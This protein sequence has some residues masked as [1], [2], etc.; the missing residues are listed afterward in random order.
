MAKLR[1]AR[2]YRKLERP[3]TRKSKYRKLSYIRSSPTCKVVKFDMGNKT[4]QFDYKLELLSGADIQIRHNALEAARMAVN[5]LMEKRAGRN[6]FHFKIRVYPHHML[7]ENPLASGA[8]ADRM[9]TGM[10]FSFG[11]VIGIAARVKRGQPI[12]EINCNKAQIESAKVAFKRAI[13]K[14]A[15]GMRVRVSEN[16][17]KAN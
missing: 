3:Y 16:L 15:C 12:L 2:A 9:S 7:R 4:G 11:K 10:A 6:L 14:F 8:G 1:R 17:K 13:P 5:R